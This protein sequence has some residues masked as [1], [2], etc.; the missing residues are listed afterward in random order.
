MGVCQSRR[1]AAILAADIAG[2]SALMGA[3]ERRTVRDLKAR[4]AIVLPMIGDFGGRIVDTA[5]DGILAEFASVVN[6]VECALALQAEMAECNSAVE[7]HRQMRFRIGINLGD[8]IYD[9]VRIYGDGINVAARLESIAEPGGVCISGKVY[10]E[11]SGRLHIA[12]DDWGEQQ[13]KNIALPVRVYRVQ[14]PGVQIDPVPIRARSAILFVSHSS[15]DDAAA[16]VLEGW[17]RANGFTEMFMH[18]RTC[19]GDDVWRGAL[20]AAAGK[21]R[22]VLSL[23]TE[24][25]LASP[26][27]LAEFE[28]SLYLGKRIIPLFL[29]TPAPNLG[30]EAENRLTKIRASHHGFDLIHCLGSNGALNLGMD[31]DVANRLRTELR[32]AGAIG[33]VGVDPEVFVV[34]RESRPVPFPGLTSFGDDDADAALFYGRSREIAQA[35]EELRKMHAEHDLRPFAILGAS[36]SGKSSLLK[37]GIIPRLR[38]E[39]P[40][41]LPLRAFRPGADPLLSFAE[42]LSLTLADFGKVEAHGVIRDRLLQVWSNAER[43]RNDLT[44]TG[45]AALA[46]AL[47]FEGCKL[48]EA[49]GRSAASIL[50]SVD[51]AE[52][53]ARAEGKSAE[54]LTDYLCVALTAA[55][56]SWQLALAIRTDSFPE[57]QRHRSFRDLE[58]RGYD[59]RSIPVFRLTNVIEGPAKRYGV[60]V[61]SV[62]VDA[63]L[64][65]APK[66]DALP[67]L[68][69]ALQRLWRQY[70]ASGSLTKD[71]YEKVGGLKGLLEDAA[72]RALRGF[73]PEQDQ[74]IPTGAPAQR[75]IDLGAA[76]FVPALA[77]INDQ[78]ATIRRMAS[79]VSFNE[80]QQALLS[81]FA[82][83]RLVV[84]KGTEPDGGTVEVAHEALFREWPRLKEWL[85]P[86]RARL[87]ALRSLQIAAS[88][89]ARHARDP[90][91]VDHRN[92]RLADASALSRH[93]AY[94]HR[95]SMIDLEYLAAC[96]QAER[97]ATSRRRRLAAVLGVLAFGLIA[98]LVGWLNEA[99]LLERWRWFATIRPYMR[100]QVQPYVLSAEAER[101]LKPKDSF[102]ECAKD[103]PEMVVVPA[104]EFAMGSPPDEEAGYDTERPQHTVVFAK[105][106]AVSKYELTFDDWDACVTYGDCDPRLNDS[107]FGRGRRPVINVTWDDA[108]RYVAWLSRMT[109][110]PYRLLSEAEWEYAARA[111]TQTA[112]SWGDE[113]GK[114]KANCRGCGSEWDNRQ[115]APVGSFAPNAFGLY[116]MHGNVWE[117]V[118]DCV[119]INYNGAPKD[120]SAWTVDGDCTGRMV[121]GGGWYNLP[122]K[123]RAAVRMGDPIGG[124]YDNLG[125]RL[126]RTL[127][128]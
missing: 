95:L 91:F 6:A 2:Y 113:I 88:A 15:R 11:V 66:D 125:F 112:Y 116:D 128:P 105:A 77:Q 31:L 39:A 67:L 43:D 110:K 5:G 3:D 75:L 50:I 123:L 20:Q 126:G 70:A 124:P 96:H 17:L 35:L 97:S 38:R 102:R 46:G 57:L 36:G 114:N 82:R 30:E 22:V 29:L 56:S 58:A 18:H 89:W 47:E 101:V 12:C 62:L 109:G 33:R 72:E 99:Y 64:E 108:Q 85:E 76:T 104:G 51:Q 28:A 19:A 41:W 107:G 24:N 118:E 44:P 92:Q 27:C 4:Q 80:E 74:P 63:L 52:E 117:W 32:A 100:T 73:E 94:R 49:A 48:R 81:R 90:G 13:L 68:A 127:I 119:H 40:A 65:D 78:G 26:D 55:T 111:G 23:V 93:D 98:G 37:A 61:D 54:A 9:E 8:I 7:P 83:W 86:E 34:D 121:R 59:L 79:W 71:N 115:P 14:V 122:E 103:C 69:F 53:A 16:K 10:D 25:W 84:H 60:E 87:E 42:A 45:S 106:F 21:C 120:G 1:L